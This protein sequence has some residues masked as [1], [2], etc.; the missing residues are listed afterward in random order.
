MS[1]TFVH[2]EAYRGKNLLKTLA[3]KHILV[4]GAGALGSNLVDTLCRQGFSTISVI[5]MD[6]VEEHNINTQ[7]FDL[8]DVGSKKVAALQKRV[9]KATEVSITP[10]DKELDAGNA[11]K[12]FKN[13]DLI[14]DTFDN[15][16]SREIVHRFSLENKVEALHAGMFEDYGEV[17]W[18]KDYR[19]PQESADAK[20]VCDYP[21]TRNLVYFV[22][23][24]AAEE[25]VNFCLEKTPRKKNWSVTLKDMAIKGYK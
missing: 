25:I 19:V 10:I 23:T 20:D 4:C 17:V 5:D 11:K 7:A 9:F 24:M 21:L 2:E 14:V 12:F 13:V 18:N 8:S 6:R 22:V 1:K 15:T 16:K 3:S